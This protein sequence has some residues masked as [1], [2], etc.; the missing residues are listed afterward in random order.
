MSK[1]NK[2][3]AVVSMV[4]GSVGVACAQATP[5]IEL[6]AADVTQLRTD[7]LTAAGVVIGLALLVM[8]FR[9]IRRLIK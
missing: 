2:V 9:F 8:A 5:L 1:I 7:F 4:M 6:P 3:L